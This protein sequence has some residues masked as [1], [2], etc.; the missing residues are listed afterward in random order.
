MTPSEVLRW[1]K[2]EFAKWWSPEFGTSILTEAEAR[3]PF[4]AGFAA[5]IVLAEAEE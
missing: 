4:I 1:A 2:E 5:A 3:F